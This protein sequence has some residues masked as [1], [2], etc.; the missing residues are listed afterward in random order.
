MQLNTEFPR[1]NG[2]ILLP[3]GA[4][5]LLAQVSKFIGAVN[6]FIGAINLAGCATNRSGLCK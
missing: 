1:H 4:S 5:Q 3:Q 2:L 6:L